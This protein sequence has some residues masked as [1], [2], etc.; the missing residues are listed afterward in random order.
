MRRV[1]I[2][3]LA[4]GV[5]VILAMILVPPWSYSYFGIGRRNLPPGRIGIPEAELTGTVYAPVFRPPRLWKARVNG[6][7]LAMQCGAVAML[8]AGVAWRQGGFVRRE[9]AEDEGEG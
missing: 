9:R 3:T 5:V 1:T 2:A 4:V 8:T 6:R 7:R